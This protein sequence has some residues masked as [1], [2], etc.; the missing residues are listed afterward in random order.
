MRSAADIFTQFG[1]MNIENS[2]KGN[3]ICAVA[4]LALFS[5]FGGCFYYEQFARTIHGGGIPR[6]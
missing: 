2:P 1:T 5:V 4:I 3:L 6:Y